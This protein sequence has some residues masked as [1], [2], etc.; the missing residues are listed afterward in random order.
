MSS[1]QNG[2]ISGDERSNIL[3]REDSSVVQLRL[4]ALLEIKFEANQVARLAHN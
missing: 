4:V 1:S 2:P 3:M